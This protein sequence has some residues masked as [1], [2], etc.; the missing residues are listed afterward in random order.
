MR[1]LKWLLAL[2]LIGLTPAFLM[3]QVDHQENVANKT[4]NSNFEVMLFD[5]VYAHRRIDS[6]VTVLKDSDGRKFVPLRSV[7]VSLGYRLQVN[8]EEHKVTGF[9]A[10]LS[11]RVDLDLK[12]GSGICRGSAVKFD[13]TTCFEQ[14]GD[15]YVESTVFCKWANF[16][17]IWKMDRLE[18]DVVSEHAL[19]I[20]HEVTEETT[21]T[22]DLTDP[23]KA[24]KPKALS[25]P[26]E[27]ITLPQMDFRLR[28]VVGLGV[29]RTND[30]STPSL[31]GYGDLLY[32]GAK[33]S[34]STDYSGRPRA[35]L[36]LGRSDPHNGLLGSLHASKVEF[37]DLVVPPISLIQTGNSGVGVSVTNA[38]MQI[39]DNAWNRDIEGDAP[40]N[41]VVELYC[42]GQ[43]QARMKANAKGHYK[44]KGIRCHEGAN[45]FTLVTVDAQ[46]Q[47]VEH[48]RTV[49]GTALR[50][51]KGEVRYSAFA[52]K[53]GERLFGEDTGIFAR[54]KATELGLELNRGVSESSW[55][56]G[57]AFQIDHSRYLGLGFNA[58]VGTALSKVEAVAS[59][60]GSRTISLGLSKRI[61]NS[62]LS[63]NQETS[64]GQIGDLRGL[65][66]NITSLSQIRFGG[67]IGRSDPISFSFSLD[68]YNGS[69]PTTFVR[70]RANKM[71]G[72]LSVTNDVSAHLGR[73]FE[74]NF[75][76]TTLRHEFG[77]SIARFEFGYGFGSAEYYRLSRLSFDQNFS[78]NF[79]I[80]Y[81]L[82]NERIS[83]KTT[84]F[85]AIYRPVGSLAV[86][87]DFRATSGNIR[88]G[89]LIST[90]IGTL[91][92]G[93]RYDFRAPNTAMGATI[94][95]RIFLDRNMSGKYD[96]GD[97][98]LPDVGLRISGRG[99]PKLSN[100]K[101]ICLVGG[102]RSGQEVSVTLDDDS[103]LDPSWVAGSDEVSIL[104]RSGKAVQIDLPVVATAELEGNVTKKTGDSKSWTGAEARLVNHDGVCV[105]RSL[106]GPDGD[107][108]FSR[109]WPSQYEI[110]I[111][112][113][114]GNVL[115]KKTQVARFGEV[116]NGIKVPISN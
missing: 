27:L 31:E 33:Y 7:G 35:D 15:L 22:I 105:G 64:T 92:S 36:T 13:P 16:D 88:L 52:C 58:W 86:G 73:N 89:F 10:N 55:L 108:I 99:A 60:D 72:N 82:E 51:A 14:D 77:S 81:G 106:V 94:R 79:R 20:P 100:K 76:L 110:W 85:G 95:A 4:S 37:G 19:N 47:I 32:M 40:A 38:P 80:Q 107:F 75:G 24:K 12:L 28:K 69:N 101:G 97:E 29:N 43:C 44:F 113:S 83:N 8:L 26:Y 109:V 84:I 102:L 54:Q 67:L 111:V 46:N 68:R 5:F 23:A 91:D 62:T 74:E 53:T 65:G 25:S 48:R 103:L 66:T 6:F 59:D 34:E 56:T 63:L 2:W 96:E 93:S 71:F 112:D 70:A 21:E 41:S 42:E 45:V 9:L 39:A 78:S 98:L 17:L 114:D 50:L 61:G 1:F 104:L 116:L 3:A 90:G 57:L 115:A 11:D 49:Y 18:V 30:V 87:L